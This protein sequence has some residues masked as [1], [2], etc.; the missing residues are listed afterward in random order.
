MRQGLRRLL[1]A[2]AKGLTANG[3]NPDEEE[4]LKVDEDV[5]Y[6]Q[7]QNIDAEPQW[8]AYRRAVQDRQSCLS[9]AY[10]EHRL[11]K[12]CRW[13]LCRRARARRRSWPRWRHSTR[14][15]MPRWRGCT[16]GSGGRGGGGRVPTLP[17]ATAQILWTPT[18]TSARSRRTDGEGR[19]GPLL[20][21]RGGARLATRH[22][23]LESRESRP[24]MAFGARAVRTA[25]S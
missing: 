7:Q 10:L 15:A 22:A 17:T 12:A 21:R 6:R 18:R 23:A 16:G 11:L 5:V 25:I 19:G 14:P 8:S 24:A 20:E 13:H 4:R 3:A 1:S 2:M 9:S